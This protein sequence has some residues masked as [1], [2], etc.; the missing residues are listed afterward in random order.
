[1]HSGGYSVDKYVPTPQAA[2][3]ILD[4]FRYNN[5]QD[6]NTWQQLSRTK[7]DYLFTEKASRT[8]CT[9]T[10]KWDDRRLP[11][12]S[13]QAS[14]RVKRT[15][16]KRV[17]TQLIELLINQG[18][19]GQGFRQANF[20]ERLPRRRRSDSEHSLSSEEEDELGGKGTEEWRAMLLRGNQ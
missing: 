16:K 2:A 4:Y 9:A 15:A 14:A 20:L 13:T 3:I 12:I 11:S 5:F 10:L 17:Q 1:M 8:V 19:I 7:V 6:F 18:Y